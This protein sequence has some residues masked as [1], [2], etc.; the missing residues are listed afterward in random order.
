MG[1]IGKRQIAVLDAPSNL[2]L[3]PPAKGAVPGVYKLPWALRRHRLIERLGAIDAG[4]VVPPRYLSQWTPGIV[5]NQEAI[6]AYSH[7]LAKRLAE[8]RQR[9]VFPLVLG[10][11]CSIILGNLLA[12]RQEGRF[13]L[14]YIDGHSD[15]RH[16]GNSDRVGAAAGEDLALLTGRGHALAR[17]DPRGPLV[18]D[19]DVVAIGMRA[20]DD[21]VAEMRTAGI[22]VFDVD[23]L[24]KDLDQ[25]L[26][27]IVGL[28][29]RDQLNG[30]WL[31]LDV[32]VLDAEIMPAV[33]SPDPGGLTWPELDRIL[34]ELGRS[35][36]IAGME[37]TIFD[38]DLDPSG[39]LAADLTDHLTK[40]I[41]PF[42][43]NQ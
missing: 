36:T 30:F 21:Y 5:R 2:G 29:E 28:L 1:T 22:Q 6:D 10:G 9:G 17:L 14:A 25:A 3:R 23:D 18:R 40:T 32:D 20:N 43:P 41:T 13:G 33:D 35:P 4:A 31:H 11:D 12:L 38:P 42:A 26:G 37:L 27:K 34:Q 15:F 19:D 7:A 8:L 39:S 24:R 16:P